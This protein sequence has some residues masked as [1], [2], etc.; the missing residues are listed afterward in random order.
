MKK[1]LTTCLVINLLYINVSI[2]GAEK[3]CNV[4]TCNAGDKAVTYA[5]KSDFSYACP[6]RELSEYTNFVLGLVSTAITFT[7]HMPNISDKTGEPEYKDVS[8][9]PNETRVMLDNFRG[10]A[11]VGTFDQALALCNKE[12]S[13]IVVT[14]MNNPSDSQSIW[15]AA[16]KSKK[17]FWM[18]KSH[19]DKK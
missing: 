17:S 18:N 5:T 6:T 3:A 12:P 7:G 4:L 8:G 10:N 19:L 16:D 2:A 11:K 14:I 15:V 13:K 9:K 1:I